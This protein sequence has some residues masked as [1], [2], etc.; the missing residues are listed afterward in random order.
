MNN[1]NKLTIFD[2][3]LS[4]DT[5]NIFI[6]RMSLLYFSFRRIKIKIITF[7]KYKLMCQV[8]NYKTKIIE[9]TNLKST[10]LRKTCVRNQNL[11]FKFLFKCH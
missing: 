5:N 2:I 7:M 3:I 10:S 1:S 4:R 11:K 6:S 9:I 8:L